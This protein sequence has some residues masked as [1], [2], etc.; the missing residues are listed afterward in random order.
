[1][2]AIT[3]GHRTRDELRALPTPILLAVGDLVLDPVTPRDYDSL[4]E[5]LVVDG[6]GWRYRFQGC[7]PPPEDFHRELTNGVG[8]NMVVRRTGKAY[9][10]FPPAAPPI[11][12]ALGL[13][14]I[15]GGSQRDRFAYLGVA[16]GHEIQR[17]PR[18]SILLGLFLHHAFETFGFRKIYAEMPEYTYRDIAS[19]Q[20]RFFDVEGRLTDHFI[21]PGGGY[22]MFIL[23]IRPEHVA[24]AVERT[25]RTASENTRVHEERRAS[26]LRPR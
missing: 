18:M 9:V 15:Y 6:A 3:D 22:D 19:G 4:F 17:D 7:T 12:P 21:R 20:G 13:L 25:R 14:Q 24:A 23:A 8:M 1:M 11:A 26:A 5:L 2:S 16:L 10:N